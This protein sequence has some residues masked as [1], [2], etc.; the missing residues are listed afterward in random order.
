MI[1][2][3]GLILLALC[4]V[5]ITGCNKDDDDP[6]EQES[7]VGT[8]VG[9]TLHYK[10]TPS[11]IGFGLGDTDDNFDAVIEFREDGT[12]VYRED[13]D[14]TSGTYNVNGNQIETSLNIPGIPFTA[15]TLKINELTKTELE[16]YFEEEGEYDVPEFGSMEGTFEATFNFERQ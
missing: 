7:I 8:W 6:T 5:L 16:L 14:E 2:K 4:A 9:T 11:S 15:S 13:G 12:V 1:I 10:F 3:N